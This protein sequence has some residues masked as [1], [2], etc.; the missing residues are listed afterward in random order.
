MRMIELVLQF[1]LLPILLINFYIHDK[2]KSSFEIRRNNFKIFKNGHNVGRTKNVD[3]KAKV[4]F[5]FPR[6]PLQRFN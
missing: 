5:R 1:Y 4:L 2:T 6:F 3:Q